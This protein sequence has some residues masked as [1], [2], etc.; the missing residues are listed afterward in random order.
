MIS[1][2]SGPEQDAPVVERAND[3]TEELKDL[4]ID[5]EDETLLA[6]GKGKVITL[7]LSW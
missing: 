5:Q 2:L 1:F 7:A 6:A 4:G 3:E